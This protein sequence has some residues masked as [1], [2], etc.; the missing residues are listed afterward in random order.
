LLNQPIR[1]CFS[2]RIYQLLL[3]LG[4]LASQ[5]S[6]LDALEGH[7]NDLVATLIPKGL[8]KRGRRV[9]VDLVALPYHG[10]VDEAHHDEVCRSRGS[11]TIHV[12]F[13]VGTL[14]H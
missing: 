13:P 5:F 6:D 1:C 4:T 9:A 8:G 12:N 11:R 3:V 14:F 2:P 10:T 7:L